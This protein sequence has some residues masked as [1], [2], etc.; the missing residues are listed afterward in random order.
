MQ[1]KINKLKEDGYILL[2][3]FFPK[4]K[5]ENIR[6]KCEKIFEI[7]FERFGYTGTFKE[8]IIKLFNE[9]EDV[10]INC[11][12]I[13][14]QG[15]IE[16]YSIS[17][18][19]LLI[20][21]LENLGIEFPNMCTRPVLFFNHPSLAKEER[22]YKTPL[23]QD[24]PSMESSNDSLVVWIPLVDVTKEM[25][26]VILYPGTHKLGNICDSIDGG[27]ATIKNYDLN[28]Y[29]EVQPD[30]NMGDIVIF[31]TFLVHKSGD[32][33]NGEIRWSCH[34]R[35]TNMRDPDYIERNFPNPYIYKPIIQK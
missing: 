35:Y 17:V 20:K 13:I 19:P 18:D 4:D 22:Y 2:K 14:Q 3:D 21:E 7:Q 28:R 34:L 24:W 1:E 5:V 32:I 25:G 23:H 16:L 12:K 10:F 31:S 11:G 8:N 27:F 9:R 6:K 15:L 26:G 33:T 29:D 30:V